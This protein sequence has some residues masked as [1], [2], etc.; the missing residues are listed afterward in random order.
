MSAADSQLSAKSSSETHSQEG[1]NDRSS[2]TRS[3]AGEKAAQERK[4]VLSEM[5]PT[6]L[7]RRVV[8]AQRENRSSMNLDL[9]RETMIDS[10]KLVGPPEYKDEFGGVD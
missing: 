8:E 5:T 1:V 4:C 9:W 6:L 3:R 2:N 10:D 7:M